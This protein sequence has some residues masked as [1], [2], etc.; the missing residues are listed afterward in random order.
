MPTILTSWVPLDA[1]TARSR[2]VA[3][4][5]QMRKLLRSMF[6]MLQLPAIRRELSR[7]RI[8]TTSTHIRKVLIT[9]RT[10]PMILFRATMIR[11]SVTV[12]SPI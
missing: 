4:K 11:I 12:I 6:F 3:M 9:K 1:P 10:R 2:V 5:N 8:R 7:F